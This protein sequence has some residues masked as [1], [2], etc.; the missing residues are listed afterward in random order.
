MISMQ[1]LIAQHKSELLRMFD[2][3][4]EDLRNQAAQT[5]DRLYEAAVKQIEADQKL[6]LQEK[7]KKRQDEVQRKVIADQTK[8]TKIIKLDVVSRLSRNSL[9]C[10]VTSPYPVRFNHIEYSKEPFLLYFS[11]HLLVVH[12]MGREV[13]STSPHGRLFA[14]LDHILRPCSL[15]DMS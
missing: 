5:L 15:D 9:I 11:F 2:S 8:N 13:S 1:N 14:S 4:L 6:L 12:H 3:N 10:L 7:K